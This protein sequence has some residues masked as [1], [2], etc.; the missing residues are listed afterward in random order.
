MDVSLSGS[1]AGTEYVRMLCSQTVRYGISK[2]KQKVRSG[3][4]LALMDGQC[5][6]L[7]T[8]AGKRYLEKNVCQY[9]C[10]YEH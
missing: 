2:K 8:G 3:R 7:N 1:G 9:F 4:G 5:F 10:T 6:E